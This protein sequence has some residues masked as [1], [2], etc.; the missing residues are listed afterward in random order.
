MMRN[1]SELDPEHTLIIT[2][3]ASLKRWTRHFLNGAGQIPEIDTLEQWLIKN[4]DH[5]VSECPIPEKWLLRSVCRKAGPEWQPAVQ[6]P[7]ILQDLLV[8]LDHAESYG[9]TA[10]RMLNEWQR[11]KDRQGFSKI[12]DLIRLNPQLGRSL[13]GKNVLFI[14]F[15]DVPPIQQTLIARMIENA[16]TSSFFLY[17]RSIDLLD[18]LKSLPVHVRQFEN[19]RGESGP[20]IQ[21]SSPQTRDE[22][23][24]D[25]ARQI[26]THDFRDVLVVV[27]ESTHYLPA[28]QRVFFEYAI[29]VTNR[30]KSRLTDHP[31]GAIAAGIL[32]LMLGKMET[33]QL[34]RFFQLPLAREKPDVAKRIESLK[35]LRE[36]TRFSADLLDIL[37]LF[38][39]PDQIMKNVF[40]WPDTQLALHHYFSLT[41]SIRNFGHYAGDS[42]RLAEDLLFWLN[43]SL[44]DIP[45]TDGVEVVSRNEAYLVRK[46]II[47]LPGMVEGQWPRQTRDNFFS[48]GWPVASQQVDTDKFLFSALVHQADSVRLSYPQSIGDT[49]TIPSHFIDYL[50]SHFQYRVVRREN[51]PRPSATPPGRGQECSVTGF[52]KRMF[53]A[54][55]L[56]T[57]QN[58][59]HQYYYKY[60]LAE[61]PIEPPTDDVSALIWGQLIH[62]ILYEFYA[63]E[64][65]R[66]S[67]EQLERVGHRVF[68]RYKKESL[69]WEVKEKLLSELLS[70]FIDEEINNPLPLK[71]AHFE[72]AFEDLELNL[73]GKIDV[74]LE[75]NGVAAVVDYKTGAT[76]PSYADI[77]HLRSL[78]LPIYMLAIRKKMPEVSCVGAII[79]QLKD[80]S[81]FGKTVLCTTPEA[82]KN[83]FQIKSKRPFEFEDHYFAK[84]Q[85]HI[86]KLQELIRAGNFSYPPR[87]DSI[88]RNCDYKLVCQYEN[89]W[90]A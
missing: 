63:D 26:A 55:Q 70:Q 86:L 34:H 17:D 15:W 80:A 38:K 67:K 74:V 42:P 36:A 60:I 59:P 46:K 13:K 53:S 44:V 14:G 61:A 20:S 24:S 9:G 56:E 85:A 77:E 25:I 6:Y 84:V 7:G 23:I 48:P 39:I 83:I 18:W 68:V 19:A 27:P 87:N 58:C 73:K 57:Y 75:S 5:P 33:K 3:H 52:E 79:Y 89:R 28:I 90:N 22:E 10:P 45:V 21:L 47:F 12:N 82:K 62:E 72:W 71:P 81:K 11:A 66:P 32:H 50:E 78:Q 43:Q 4:S 49:A 2:S 1:V 51:P 29:P 31:I 69:Y 88:C 40:E 65:N 64:K 16:E 35:R 8:F 41:E 54:T 76:L 37:A 30:K